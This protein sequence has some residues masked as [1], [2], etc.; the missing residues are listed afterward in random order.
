[1]SAL[2]N[3]LNK[4]YVDELRALPKGK[5]P[6]NLDTITSNDVLYWNDMAANMFIVLDGVLATHSKNELET[7][8][9]NK[10]NVSFTADGFGGNKG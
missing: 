6:E 4:H 3:T 2:K 5:S 9:F 1:M 7:R 8:C 10:N